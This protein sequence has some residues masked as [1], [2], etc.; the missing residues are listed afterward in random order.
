MAEQRPA[1]LGQQQLEPLGDPG[2]GRGQARVGEQAAAVGDRGR[3]DLPTT[4]QVGD[5]LADRRVGQAEQRGCGRAERLLGHP[6]VAPHGQL[7]Q[8]V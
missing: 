5:R 7:P 1:V 4:D 6:G 2:L 8:R 3:D